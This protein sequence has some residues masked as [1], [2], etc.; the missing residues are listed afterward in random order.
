MTYTHIVTNTGDLKDTICLTATPASPLSASVIPEC[1]EDLKPGEGAVFTVYVAV[2]PRTSPGKI[3]TYIAVTSTNGALAPP[4]TDETDVV[5]SNIYLPAV[6]KEY[7]Q[8]CPDESPCNWDPHEPNN[9]WCSAH[10]ISSNVPI[11]SYICA[12]ND[13][14][15]YW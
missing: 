11:Q 14:K 2:P 10:L 7:W 6:M 15:D 8:P 12:P 5:G 4:A 9:K 1:T 13:T 3:P